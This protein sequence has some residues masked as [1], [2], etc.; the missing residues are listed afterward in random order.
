MEFTYDN[1]LSTTTGVSLLFTNKKYHLNIT[2]HSEYNI[3]FSQ[4]CNFAVDLDRLQSIL[5]TEMS[6]AQ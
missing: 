5:K 4:A 2:V 6:A 3:A 1:T